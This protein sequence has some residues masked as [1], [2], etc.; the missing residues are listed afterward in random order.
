MLILHYERMFS[1]CRCFGHTL[2]VPRNSIISSV[3]VCVYPCKRKYGACLFVR[4]YSVNIFLNTLVYSKVT[5]VQ[6]PVGTKNFRSFPDNRLRDNFGK[7][8]VRRP[9]IHTFS[10]GL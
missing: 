2:Q 8:N 6:V 9:R 3:I 4:I 1:L 5:G 10:I 7:Q